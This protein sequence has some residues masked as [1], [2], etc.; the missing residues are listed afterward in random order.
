[1]KPSPRNQEWSYVTRITIFE[2][3][4]ELKVAAKFDIH[5]LLRFLHVPLDARSPDFAVA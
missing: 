4:L 1:M 3:P 2:F 5:A